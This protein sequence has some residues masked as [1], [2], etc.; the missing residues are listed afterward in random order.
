VKN[1]L[2]F[3]F[4]VASWIIGWSAASYL[5]EGHL[6][7]V[8][9]GLLAILILLLFVPRL[10]WRQAKLLEGIAGKLGFNSARTERINVLHKKLYEPTWFSSL[11]LPDAERERLDEELQE[12]AELDWHQEPAKT[13]LMVR[14]IERLQDISSLLASEELPQVEDREDWAKPDWARTG[15]LA[16]INEQLEHISGLLDSK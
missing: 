4:A 11:K 3:L 15:Q 5:L 14:I 8:S 13:F 12:L 6:P 10:L 2:G 7:Q 9:E 16:R 1:E